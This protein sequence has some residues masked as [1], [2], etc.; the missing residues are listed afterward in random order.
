MNNFLYVTKNNPHAD[1]LWCPPVSPLSH[2]Q[3]LLRCAVKS[4]IRRAMAN[5]RYSRDTIEF[6]PYYENT[7]HGLNANV[8]SVLNPQL[9]HGIKS[10]CSTDVKN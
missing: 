5:G 8:L 3:S 6:R 4:R 7:V 9:F 1:K 10:E 2:E